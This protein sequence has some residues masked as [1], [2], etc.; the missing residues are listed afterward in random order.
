MR[1]WISKSGIKTNNL[2]MGKSRGLRRV[3]FSSSGAIRTTCLFSLW[4]CPIRRLKPNCGTTSPCAI[5][6]FGIK[7]FE[8]KFGT[9]SIEQL[10]P[11]L[12]EADDD[13]ILA[14]C[15]GAIARVF[16]VD[17]V[18]RQID[19]I[20]SSTASDYPTTRKRKS[21]C[22]YPREVW[23]VPD[24]GRLGF[25]QARWVW[26]RDGFGPNFN[27]RWGALDFWWM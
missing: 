4:L 19:A 11:W 24:L 25:Q 7:R 15:G 8:L 5:R 2:T 20:S 10:Q 22:Y 12:V 14:A 27:E 21:S 3:N 17:A 26:G 13:V 1:S 9:D 23:A 6:L 18:D 16:D